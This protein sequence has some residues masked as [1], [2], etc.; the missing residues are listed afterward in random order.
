MNKTSLLLLVLMVSVITAH[1]QFAFEGGVNMAN[2]AVTSNGKS[3]STTYK[4]GPAMGIVAGLALNDA[5][6]LYFEPGL[7]F[8]ANGAKITSKPT[9]TYIIN[10]VEIPL[11]LQYKWGEKCSSR[12]FIGAGPYITANMSGSYQ[13]DADGPVPAYSGTFV[14]SP[15]KDYNLKKW[16]YGLGFN[17][18]HL[19]KKHLFFRVHYQMSLTNLA[20]NGDD[21]NS[22]KQSAA[23][24]T[25]GYAIRGC[26][27]GNRS[28]AFGGRGNTHW[29]GLRKNKYSRR[30]LFRRPNGP[31]YY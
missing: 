20:P 19:G 14:F 30:Q 3:I 26:N 1:A 12:F 16:E 31:A 13:F 7:F 29:R 23:G 10:S 21:K 4:P 2:I 27:R 17:F 15:D 6:H 28:G 18:G 9:G 25:I 11:N 22:F 8:V 24:L 5:Q